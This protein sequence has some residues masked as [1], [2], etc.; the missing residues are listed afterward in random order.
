M[1]SVQILS[2]AAALLAQTAVPAAGE[3]FY[4][5][6]HI[7]PRPMT[8]LE[9]GLGDSLSGAT[10]AEQRAALVWSLRQG[11]LLG[12][13][14][15]H[16]Q[17]PTLLT[18]AN[19]NALLTNHAQELAG[20]YKAISGYFR[21][22]E[23]GA[24]AAQRALDTYTTRSTTLYSTVRSQPNFCYTAGWI[25]RKALYVPRGGL[26]QLAMA[27]LGEL[28]D[29]L[30][31]GRDQQFLIPIVHNDIPVAGLPSLDKRCWSKKGEFNVRKCAGST[32]G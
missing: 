25:G 31:G 6:P 22:T 21:R 7:P 13:L 26:A 32:A 28:R 3:V 15:C 30:K 16:S 4:K 2:L 5:P 10:D 8:A 20:A 12:A 14:Q 24:M 9:P 19:Y 1:K 27:H 18:T 11:M 17:Y 29:S 23:K